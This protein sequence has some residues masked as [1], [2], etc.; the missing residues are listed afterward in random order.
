MKRKHED[1]KTEEAEIS[2]KERVKNEKKILRNVLLVIGVMIM[3]FVSYLVAS[4]FISNFEYEGVRFSVVSDEF[5]GVLYNTYVPVVYD[6]KNANYNFWLRN[7]PRK[8]I[9]EVEFDGD[10]AIKPLMV[11]NI[12]GD[13]NCNGDGIIAIPNLSNLYKVAGADVVK[14]S[15]VTCSASGEYSYI[16]IQAGNETKITEVAPAC[17]EISVNNCEILMATE[18]F[19]IET[20]VEL[21]KITG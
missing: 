4:Y 10:L 8:T 20:F 12:T 14:N 18:R 6:G 21:K 17:Y 16:D 11:I 9:R 1:K 7:D 2:E 3:V 5:V 13:L 15:T 19:M